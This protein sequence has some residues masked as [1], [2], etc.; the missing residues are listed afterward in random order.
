MRARLPLA[1]PLGLS[2]AL[3][4][5]ACLPPP[6]L[7][8]TIY[9][10]DP[11]STGDTDSTGDDPTPPTG[12]IQT[13]T[14]DDPTPPNTSESNTTSTSETTGVPDDPPAI[15]EFELDPNPIFQNGLIAIA[16]TAQHADGVTMQLDDGTQIELDSR[17]PDSFAGAIEAF[18]GLLNGKH[19]ALLKPWRDPQIDG[20]PVPAPYTIQ[21]PA[22]GTQLFW[23]TGDLIGPG[24]VVAMATLPTGEIVEFGNHSLKGKPRCYLRRRDKGGAWGPDDLV[25]VLPDIDCSAIDLQLDEFGALYILLNRT[26]NDGLRWWFAKISSW[27]QGAKNIGTGTKGETATALAVHPSGMVAVCGFA[28]TPKPNLDDDAMAWIFRPNQPGDVLALDYDSP[29]FLI[30]TFSEH[31]RDCQFV[32]DTLVLVGEARGTHDG[33]NANEVDRLFIT[34]TEMAIDFT[35]WTI[36]PPGATTTQSGAQTMALDDQG[37]ILVGGYVCDDECVPGGELRIY[38]PDGTLLWLAS[39]GAFPNTQW[40]ARDI[41]WSPAGYAVVATGGLKGKETGFT[42][43]AFAPFKYK[44]LWTFTREDSQVLNFANALTIGRFGEVYAGGIGANGYPAVAYIAG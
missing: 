33:E 6:L 22:P 15:V 37:R 8:C 12:G 44:P 10:C 7:D 41:A 23:E 16:V 2:L 20:T 35:T 1:L 36:D 17:E 18:S 21:L 24:E 4:L 3:S 34:T 42:V 39:L 40:T 28:P 38:D 25:E 9:D 32:D 11:T 27:G 14:G 43:R 31:T 5:A 26:S 30:H 19:E 29:D 13:V